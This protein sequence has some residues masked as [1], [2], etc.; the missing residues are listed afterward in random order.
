MKAKL[1]PLV[2]AVL[3]FTI[4]PANAAPGESSGSGKLGF[5]P[6]GDRVTLCVNPAGVDVCELLGVNAD[7]VMAYNENN[8]VLAGSH[9]TPAIGSFFNEAF[10]SAEYPLSYPAGYE[11]FPGGPAEDFL[12]KLVSVRVVVDEGTRTE[13]TYDYPP[14]SIIHRV[15]VG[16]WSDFTAADDESANWPLL[17]F[18][19]L[20]HP[21]SVGPH[22]VKVFATLSAESC[23]GLPPDPSYG[24]YCIPPGELLWKDLPFTVAPRCRP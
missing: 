7:F 20:V 8:C 16:A 14:A 22:R 5:S 1:L 13:R 6:G 12:A 19:P 10:G 4:D 24:Y 18:T 3:Q 15:T 11:P 17:E 2:A 23:D 21:L 9:W